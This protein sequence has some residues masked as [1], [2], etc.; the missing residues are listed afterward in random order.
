MPGAQILPRDAAKHLVRVLRLRA[1]DVFV[2]FDPEAGIEANARI[3]SIEKGAVRVVIADPRPAPEMRPLIWVHGLVKGDKCDAIVRDATELGATDIVIAP[4]ERSIPPLSTAEARVKRW[5]KIADEAARQSGRVRAPRIRIERSWDDAL[6]F[7]S[8]NVQ[9]EGARFCMWERATE[10][11]GPRLVAAKNAM[12]AFA[13]GPEGGLTE[14]E[15]NRARARRFEI[16]SLGS[17]ILRTETV[18]AAVLGA[19][20]I[21]SPHG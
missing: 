20:L 1:G 12:L 18:P 11:L 13:A 15:V 17:R 5:Q 14:E 6:L 3:E 21:V 9:P 8:V 19:A 2:A 16:V 10:P 7:A 4:C